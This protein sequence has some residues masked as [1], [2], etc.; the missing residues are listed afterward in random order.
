MAYEHVLNCMLSDEGLKFTVLNENLCERETLPGHLA[1][2]TAQARHI[3]AFASLE[4]PSAN[5]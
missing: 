4:L 1:R 2:L 3:F 5:E